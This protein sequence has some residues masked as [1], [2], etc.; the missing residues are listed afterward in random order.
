MYKATVTVT[1]RPSILDP[2]GKAIEHALHSLALTSVSGVR[3]GKQ[4][5]FFVDAPDRGAAEA[6][7][8]DACSRVLANPV[9]E[10]FTFT[11]VETGA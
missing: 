6:A 10:D 4:I 7:V 11:L 9:M 3:V 8:T 1:L 2:E 5:E